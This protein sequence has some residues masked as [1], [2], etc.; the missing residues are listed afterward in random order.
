MKLDNIHKILFITLSN[1]GDVVLTLPVLS[2]LRDKFPDETIDVVVGPNPKEVFTKDPRINS[3]F[4]YDKHA[5]LKD[6]IL[7]IKKLKSEKYD[8]A[9]DMKTSLIPV[10][11]AAR[12]RSP[13]ISMNKDTLRHKK[14]MHLNKLKALN[15]GFKKDMGDR[16]IYIDNRDR[17]RV[18]A[19]LEE[20]GLEK[21]DVLIGLSPACRSPLKQWHIEGFVE[22]ISN[23]IRHRDCKIVL[24]GDATQVNISSRI[25]NAV[26]HKNLI[27]LTGKI[28]LNELFALIDKMQLLITCDSASLHI[29]CDLG[30]KVAAVFGPTDP[31][32]YGP[33][34]KNDIVI[35]KRLKCSPCRKAV[36][37]FN[38]ECMEEIKAGE[39]LEAIEKLL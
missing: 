35:R 10:L 21:G 7:F 12:Y 39:V 1:I 34:G 18:K 17:E 28:N 31:E 4:I 37:K 2:A 20:H 30:I 38:H 33:T 5:G 3:V 22:V 8:L 23:L 9:V 16:N 36:C 15:I 24:I 6:K 26:N 27:D 14:T 13:L 32:E 19:L 25:Q 29:A 11:I